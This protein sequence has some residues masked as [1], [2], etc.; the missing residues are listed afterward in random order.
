[1]DYL[2]VAIAYCGLR[3][4]AGI[5][6][7][8]NIYDKLNIIEQKQLIRCIHRLS[9]VHQLSILTCGYELTLESIQQDHINHIILLSPV[10]GGVTPIYEGTIQEALQTI[11]KIFQ[12]KKFENVIDELLD[13][14]AKSDTNSVARLMMLVHDLRQSNR[15]EEQDLS[16]AIYP[17]HLNE[18]KTTKKRWLEYWWLGW[19]YWRFVSNNKKVFFWVVFKLFIHVILICLAFWNLP[20]TH[21][22]SKSMFGAMNALLF[23]FVMQTPANHRLFLPLLKLGIQ[24]WQG[25]KYSLNMM[26]TLHCWAQYLLSVVLATMTSVLSY[27]TVNFNDPATAM[28][29]SI[30][31][32][33]MG[34][35][36]SAGVWDSIYFLLYALGCSPNMSWFVMAHLLLYFWL[37]SGCFILKTSMPLVLRIIG[38]YANPVRLTLE[39]QYC[40]IILPKTFGN[41]RGSDILAES[42]YDCAIGF[43]LCL[44]FLITFILRIVGS[45]VLAYRYESIPL[46]NEHMAMYMNNNAN[47]YG[48]RDDNQSSDDD[49]DDDLDDDGQPANIPMVA[50]RESRENNNKLS[51]PPRLTGRNSRHKGH[52][53]VDHI[54]NVGS[55]NF[56]P[57]P[58]NDNDYISMDIPDVGDEEDANN[59]NNNPQKR[60]SLIKGLKKFLKKDKEKEQRQVALLQHG[61][62]IDLD[63]IGRDN[64]ESDSDLLNEFH[65]YNSGGINNNDS[66]IKYENDNNNNNN[67]NYNRMILG[68]GNDDSD[69]MNL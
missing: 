30:V 16:Q 11:P 41:E 50:T 37:F 7:I 62:E 45:F 32:F 1:M 42:D 17:L 36:Y 25:G 21:S 59:A 69:S 31:L 10:P 2:K 23:I 43:D 48:Y 40:A 20:S 39:S 44:V 24:D 54:P 18:Y 61:D 67:N 52:S 4:K 68:V 28:G 29:Y 12:F 53:S 55:I 3:S 8:E 19:L 15:I 13:I 46:Y 38:Y 34:F 63:E 35:V 5:V 33:T 60:G 64:E 65:A 47:D 22:G 49:D 56:T 57:T 66:R 27:W 9:Q 6:L 26:S 14:S 58:R 51:P